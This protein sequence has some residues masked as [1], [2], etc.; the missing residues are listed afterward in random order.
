MTCRQDV[1]TLIDKALC[2]SQSDTTFLSKT[3]FSSLLLCCR[4]NNCNKQQHLCDAEQ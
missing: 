2:R 3:F 1:G 4:A